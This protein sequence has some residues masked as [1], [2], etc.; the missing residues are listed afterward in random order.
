MS[1][2]FRVGM[3]LAERGGGQEAY[4]KTML[5]AA[6][7]RQRWHEANN[8]RAIAQAET[9]SLLESAKL[10]DGLLASGKS[11]EAQRVLRVAIIAA[12]GHYHAPARSQS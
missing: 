8:A 1:V 7:D 11:D 9:R 2:L 3:W 12:A 4:A 6:G 10:V 5:D